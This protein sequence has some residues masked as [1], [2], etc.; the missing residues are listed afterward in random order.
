MKIFK[1]LIFILL[2]SS[3]TTS[4]QLVYLN[5]G[6]S[7]QVSS[8]TNKYESEDLIQ[9]GDILKI[10]VRSI[11]VEAS[12]P[13][14]KDPILNTINSEEILK[15]YGYLVSDSGY[16]NFPVL[17]K[18]FVKDKKISSLE[19]SLKT[20]LVDNDHLINPTVNI[21]RLNAKFTVLGEV[22]RPGTFNYYDDKLNIFQAI[23]YSGDLTINAKRN[24]I[25]LIRKKN[26]KEF[27]HIIKLTDKNL[28][29]S[30]YYYIKTND[31]IIVNPNFSRIKSAGFI[32][33]P[34]SIASISSILLSLTLLLINN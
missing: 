26:G 6:S 2:I 19:N 17:G 21:R 14:T 3:C 23:G 24:N 29:N 7:E 27:V 12:L 5:N 31:V 16:I 11:S 32:G 33:S 18:I 34:S 10:D 9:V 22:A 4:T 25:S 13:Y 8:W 30:P 1:Y 28:L 15:L 20:I